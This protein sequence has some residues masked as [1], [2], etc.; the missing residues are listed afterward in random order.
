MNNWRYPSLSIHGIEGAFS[1][2]GFKTVIPRKVIGK[3]SIRLVPDQEPQKIILL[4]KDYIKKIWEK[5]QSPNN[6]EVTYLLHLFILDIFIVTIN[7]VLI[8]IYL[9]VSSFPTISFY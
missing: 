5:R 9:I 6:L 2:P 3:F 7:F 1:G 8:Q 4:V